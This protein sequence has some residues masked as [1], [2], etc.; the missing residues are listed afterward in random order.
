[1]AS[2][3]PLTDAALDEVLEDFEMLA[4]DG[5][6][7]AARI[8]LDAIEAA[9]D[10]ED[11]ERLYAR[12]LFI[13]ASEGPNDA[14]KAA[15]QRAV[16]VAPDFADA[17][18]A[19]GRLADLQGD[20][21]TLRAQWL[22]VLALDSAQPRPRGES[23]RL[24]EIESIANEVFASIPDEFRERLENVPVVLEPRPH[25]GLV[26]EGFDPRAL[27]LFEGREAAERHEAVTA[28]TRIVLFYENLLDAFEDPQRLAEEIEV[29]MLHEIGHYF[30]LDEH[31][32]EALG[33]G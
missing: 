33:L 29:T 28:P 27:G 24:D 23:A 11:P 26:E 2:P 16:E 32:V 10:D 8:L 21:E 31:G 19:L 13:W 9:L 6:L 30:G 1:M 5:R 15:L 17:R 20:F 4:F 3:P 22:E 7:H 12:A 18:H 25:R 14:A